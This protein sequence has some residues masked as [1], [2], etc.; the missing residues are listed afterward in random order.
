MPYNTEIFEDMR[1]SE[2]EKK[3]GEERPCENIILFG[4]KLFI[5]QSGGSFSG[6]ANF[7]K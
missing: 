4:L 2:N 7:E 5:S 1:S 6:Q 3:M